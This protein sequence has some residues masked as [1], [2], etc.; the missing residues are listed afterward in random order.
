MMVMTVIMMVVILGAIM[1]V[2]NKYK[3]HNLI[4]HFQHILV[5][6]WIF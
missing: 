5:P 3:I 4:K 6:P 1:M 2:M